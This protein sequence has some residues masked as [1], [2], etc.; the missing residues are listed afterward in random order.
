MP[1]L[2]RGPSQARELPRAVGTAKKKKKSINSTQIS[3][4]KKKRKGYL[5]TFYEASITLMP[6]S[7][8]YNKNKENYRP[9]T[10]MIVDTKNP[11]QGAP[12][13]A[14][15]DRQRLGNAGTRAR[16]LAQ[17]SQ[18]RIRCCYSCSSDL[19][20]CMGVPCASGQP[21]TNKQTNKSLPKY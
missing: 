9:I 3:F 13:V 4:R 19:I 16:S 10:I 18:L 1:L 20:P 6:K 11:Y 21:K 7:G 17:Y 5:P 12:A 15:W 14:Q 2:W 8:K